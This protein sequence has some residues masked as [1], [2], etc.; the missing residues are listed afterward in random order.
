M[1]NVI[2]LPQETVDE[3]TKFER[4]WV[5]LMQELGSLKINQLELETRELYLKQHYV[6][7]SNTRDNLYNNLTQQYG[8][9]ELNLEQKV[10]L[11]K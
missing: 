7:L 2:P 4:M 10:Y 5:E 3:F 1:N 8:R 6:D 11:P 9:G